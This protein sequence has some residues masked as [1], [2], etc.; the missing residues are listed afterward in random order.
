MTEMFCT[1]SVNDIAALIAECHFISEE[2]SKPLFLAESLPQHVVGSPEERRDLLRFAQF[3]TDIP[4]AKY[5]SGRIFHQD[6]ELRWEKND[7]KI[8]VVYVGT[9]RRL[10]SALKVVRDLDLK[11]REEPKYYYLFGTRLNADELQEIGIPPEPGYYA[12]VRIPR[13]LRYPAPEGAMR[14]QLA[15]CEYVDEATGKVELFRFQGLKAAE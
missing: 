5:T 7:G 13:L 8:D 9:E 11:K 10:P 15:V 6:F 12:E 1:G 14:V 4:F 2:Q 3:A